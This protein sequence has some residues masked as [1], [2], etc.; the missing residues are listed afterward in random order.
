MGIRP[1]RTE[2]DHRDALAEIERVMAVPEEALPAAD[3]DRLEVLAVLVEDY[4]RRHHAVPPA[5]PIEAVEFMMGQKGW[6]RAD[7]EPLIGGRGRVSEVMTR[8]RAL[9]IGMIR[10]LSEALRIPAEVLVAPYDLRPDP[11]PPPWRKP[12]AGKRAA[13]APSKRAA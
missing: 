3:G 1:I 8:R 10:A 12:V 11:P 5:D 4:E 2:A 9:S 6:T 13:A 7:L